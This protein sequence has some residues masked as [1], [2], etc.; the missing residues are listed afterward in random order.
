MPRFEGVERHQAGL[1][2]LG[3][4]DTPERLRDWFAILPRSEAHAVSQQV[5]GA[6]LAAQQSRCVRSD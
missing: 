6:N 5:H 3:A 2:R 1:G 4:V